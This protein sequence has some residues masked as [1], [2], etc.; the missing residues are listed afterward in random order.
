MPRRRIRCWRI[1][2]L[3][4]IAFIAVPA[5]AAA[6]PF[7]GA[8]KWSV[9]LCR[10]SDSG[11]PHRTAAYFRSMILPRGTGL[12]RLPQNP[13]ASGGPVAGLCDVHLGKAPAG[14]S[15]LVGP[16]TALPQSAPGP[17]E[18]CKWRVF[19]RS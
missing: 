14:T 9:L 8:A 18:Q 10:F 12:V 1:A 15:T 4:M 11:A 16:S 19:A 2:A 6:R 13:G 7:R 17:Q 5:G 3:A